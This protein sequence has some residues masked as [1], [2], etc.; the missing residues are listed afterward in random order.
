MEIGKRLF[1]NWMVFQH[2][3]NTQ[4]RIIISLWYQDLQCTLCTT[5]YPVFDY[6]K[7]KSL[8]HLL[9]TNIRLGKTSLV[10]ALSCRTTASHTP[11]LH[12]TWLWR[13]HWIGFYE[14]QSLNLIYNLNVCNVFS[15]STLENP[16]IIRASP[17]L[18]D[19]LIWRLV[20][21]KCRASGHWRY[22]A[23]MDLCNVYH[24]VSLSS[25]TFHLK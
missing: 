23:T 11:Y 21:R 25:R 2:S 7:W 22:V 6:R 16:A 13:K 17:V 12:V 10:C 18:V 24:I 14:A 15:S 9:T 20:G 19:Y 1:S 5:G 3:I 8:Q 4:Q